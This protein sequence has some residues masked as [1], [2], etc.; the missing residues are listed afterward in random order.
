MGKKRL[1]KSVG[2]IIGNH[3]G[4]NALRP[5]MSAGNDIT[6]VISKTGTLSPGE[7]EGLRSEIR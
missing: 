5:Y 6:A 1:M 3:N 4:S 7:L 2:S